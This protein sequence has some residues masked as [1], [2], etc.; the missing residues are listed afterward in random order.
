MQGQSEYQ[1][2]LKQEYNYLNTREAEIKQDIEMGERMMQLNDSNRKKYYAYINIIMVWVSAIIL[3]LI[4]VYLNRF[5]GVP[6]KFFFALIVTGAIIWSAY[7]LYQIQ[8]R[9]PTD[10]DKLRLNGPKISS[11]PG[12]INTTSTGSKNITPTPT[13]TLSNNSNVCVGQDCC[14]DGYNYNSEPGHNKCEQFTTIE[15]ATT[16]G[17]YSTEQEGFTVEKLLDFYP[18]MSIGQLF[19]M[20]LFNY[21]CEGQTYC[22]YRDNTF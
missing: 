3:I 9:D 14:P 12:S 6:F 8:K 1:N 13:T 22:A 21:A 10:F 2:V 17:E 18:P 4:F 16:N 15:Q 20:P 5:F 11:S 19:N 7:L